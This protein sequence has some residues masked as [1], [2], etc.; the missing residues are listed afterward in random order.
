M[1]LEPDDRP[2]PLLQRPLNNGYHLQNEGERRAFRWSER[3][4]SIAEISTRMRSRPDSE[5]AA[6]AFDALNLND[7][8]EFGNGDPRAYVAYEEGQH[9]VKIAERLL[10]RAPDGE[11]IWF[12]KTEVKANFSNRFPW[13]GLSVGRITLY[14]R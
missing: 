6:N 4:A 3:V 8:E 11:R 13:S 14:Y 9:L 2:D 5:S 1:L 12:T 7:I 10:M